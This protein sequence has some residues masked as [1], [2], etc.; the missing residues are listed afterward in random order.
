MNEKEFYKQL[1]SEYSFN[2]E[3]IKKAAMGKTIEREKKSPL[4][5]IASACAAA[6]AIVS[7]GAA[8]VIAITS[9]GN[10]VTVT[11]TNSVSIEDRFKLALEAYEKADQNTEAVFLYVTFVKKETPTAMQDILAR[12]DGTGEIKVIE[13]YNSDNTAVSGSANIK[14]L[15]EADEENIIAVKIRC[16][17]NF[18]KRLSKDRDVYLVE[19]EAAFENSNFSA[20]DTN[21]SAPE[22]P[23]TAESETET[24]TP[25]DTS[26]AEETTSQ[27]PPPVVGDTTP[28]KEEEPSVTLP[29]VTTPVTEKTTPDAPQTEI[30]PAPETEITASESAPSSETTPQPISAVE[31][32][33]IG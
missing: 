30:T 5:W 3:K 11:P 16:P 27:T 28:P 20:I 26:S 1:M 17:G 4:K 12:A 15:F 32:E 33:N 14:A 19:T 23:E 24:S 2:H 8:G 6:V 9:G 21:V 22:M 31:T 29:P 10:P 25:E 18:I 7:V 13:V